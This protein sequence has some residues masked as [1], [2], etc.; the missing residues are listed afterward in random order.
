MRRSMNRV[1]EGQAVNA[2]EVTAVQFDAKAFWSDAVRLHVGNN[3]WFQSALAGDRSK[4]ARDGGEQEGEASEPQ[5]E[6]VDGKK[7]MVKRKKG[8]SRDPMTA[9]RREETN[10]IVNAF[11]QAR[12]G[13]FGMDD[14][15]I[16]RGELPRSGRQVALYGLPGA[17]RA[18]S[19][20]PILEGF[21]LDE[22]DPLFW[23]PM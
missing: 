21:S 2:V 8:R 15:M 13:P 17:T 23:V 7:E 11:Q 3:H 1:L 6:N 10:K 12:I 20:T 9:G 16:K 14:K 5:E 22:S 4:K 19:L 18:N